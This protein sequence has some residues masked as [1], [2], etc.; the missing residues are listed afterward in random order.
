MTDNNP[1]SREQEFDDL[2]SLKKIIVVGSCIPLVMYLVWQFLILSIIPQT[3]A[4]GLI[5]I[6]KNSNS[7]EM[8]SN[9]LSTDMKINHVS[10]LNNSFSF[11]A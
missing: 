4:H 2:P 6:A 5:A 1:S 11:F 8:L 7:L 10:S 9:V 3:G